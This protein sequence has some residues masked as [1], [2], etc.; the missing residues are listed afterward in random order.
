VSATK[1][2]SGRPNAAWLSPSQRVKYGAA[3]REMLRESPDATLEQLTTT[4]GAP[5][6]FCAEVRRRL[7]QQKEAAP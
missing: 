7:A 5:P 6:A 3:V 1:P 4:T 2:L